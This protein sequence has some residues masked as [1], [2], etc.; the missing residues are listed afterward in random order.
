MSRRHVR[1]A[2]Y[3]SLKAIVRPALLHAGFGQDLS[4]SGPE[5]QRPVAHSGD[6]GGSGEDRPPGCAHAGEALAGGGT[7]GRAD[8]LAGEQETLR[9][10][11]RAREDAKQA[12]L[13]ARQR[14]QAVLLRYALGYGGENW[15]PAPMRW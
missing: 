4:D 14:I 2:A 1:C 9:D 6:S 8:M 10:L 13:V 15:S 7:D 3:E 11:C 5:P 12:E